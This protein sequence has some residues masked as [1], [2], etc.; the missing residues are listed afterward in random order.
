ML[1]NHQIEDFEDRIHVMTFLTQRNGWMKR[2][3]EMMLI[4]TS[5]TNHFQATLPIA[6]TGCYLTKVLYEW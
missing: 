1:L 4:I 5:F 3:V 6:V 2:T